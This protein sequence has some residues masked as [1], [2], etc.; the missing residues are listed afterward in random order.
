MLFS[1]FS[2]PLSDFQLRFAVCLSVKCLYPILCK[3][4]SAHYK[5]VGVH[6]SP[7]MLTY[8]KIAF[9]RIRRRSALAFFCEAL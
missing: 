4:D 3:Y 8:I 1:R 7:E 9:Q 5:V 6:V 2:L